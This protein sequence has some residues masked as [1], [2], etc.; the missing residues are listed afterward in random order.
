MKSTFKHPKTGKGWF[1]L[2]LLVF[3]IMLGSWPIIPFFN[4]EIIAF[5]MPLLMTWSV[6]LIIFT[7]FAMWLIN[8]I[9]G[10]K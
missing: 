8:K 5:G 9:G 7:S 3:V 1:S 2:G 10:V 6:I 4:K